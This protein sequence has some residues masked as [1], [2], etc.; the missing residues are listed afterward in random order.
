MSS[1][2][3]SSGIEY[4]EHL[5]T[6]T[7]LKCMPTELVQL[8]VVYVIDIEDGVFNFGQPLSEQDKTKLL[9][10]VDIEC[11]AAPQKLETF[12]ALQGKPL[13]LQYHEFPMNDSFSSNDAVLLET[14]LK[15][16]LETCHTM[17]GM[18]VLCKTLPQFALVLKSIANAFNPKDHC[19]DKLPN[20]KQLTL[21]RDLEFEKRISF[22]PLSPDKKCL[23]YSCMSRASAV[24]KNLPDS[25]FDETPLKSIGTLVSHEAASK[26]IQVSDMLCR[27]IHQAR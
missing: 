16:V 8:I 10:N 4:I 1:M 21:V 26:I 27:D 23:S 6:N 25:V 12:F 18:I 5:T 9:Q 11:Y 3:S 22:V 24:L 17:K 14:K 2:S 20:V 7:P 19:I 15:E 13:L